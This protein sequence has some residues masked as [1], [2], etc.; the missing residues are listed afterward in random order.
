MGKVIIGPGNLDSIVVVNP[1]DLKEL[2]V[3]TVQ[4]PYFPE[5]NKLP[6]QDNRL[7]ILEELVYDLPDKMED[8]RITTYE[9]LNEVRD[10]QNDQVEKLHQIECQL[11]NLKLEI[12]VKQITVHENYDDR[13]IRSLIQGV[14]AVIEQGQK[15]QEFV[16][17]RFRRDINSLK[18]EK[19]PIS[20]IVRVHERLPKWVMYGFIFNFLLALIGFLT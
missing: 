8:L 5:Q 13:D 11:Q 20:E 16:N 3:E 6:L 17:E 2:T 7:V 18:N 10:I 4:L 1:P 12:P 14:M 9:S 15:G 19:Q